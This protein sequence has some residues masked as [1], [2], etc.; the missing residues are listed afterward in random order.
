[1]RLGFVAPAVLSL[2]VAI[3]CGGSAD[4]SQVQGGGSAANGNGDGVGG[5]LVIGGD[6]AAASGNTAYGSGDSFDPNSACA[7]SAADGEP[8]PV[9]LYFMVDTTGSMNC[10]V[11]DQGPCDA[12]PGPPKTG[13]SRWTLVSAAL[14]SFVTAPANQ[15]LGVGINFFPSKDDRQLCQASAYAKPLVEIGPLSTTGAAISTNISQQ[16]PGG[17][18]PTVPSLQ[19]AIEHAATWAKANPTHR[20]AVVYATDGYPKGCR[21]NTIDAAA[22]L[23]KAGFAATP[24]VPVY[25][26]GVGPNLTNLDSIAIGGGTKKAFLVDTTQD[27]AAQLSAALATIRGN[28]VLDCT[29]SIPPAPTGQ[30]LEPGKVN[31]NVTNSKGVATKVLQDPAGVS[32]D[33]G[34]GWQYSSDGKQIN[35]CG[36]ACNAVKADPGGKIQVLF[37]CTT[38][39]GNPP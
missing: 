20:V 29:Y 22:A 4:P 33:K 27:A 10:P 34:T 7:N 17:Q 38:E 21:G 15:G 28:A 18:T 35:L 30:S 12:D 32:C 16:M 26:L 39:V 23:A 9:D 3:A 8:I 36:A 11:P 1:M 37:G 2:F 13:E 31:V 6:G 5:G 25:V 24:S 14:K 19:A